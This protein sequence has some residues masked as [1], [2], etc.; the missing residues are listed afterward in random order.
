MNMFGNG[1]P[2]VFGLPKHSP[3]TTPKNIDAMAEIT[4]KVKVPIATGE[5]I[6]TKFGFFEVL[7]KTKVAVIQPDLSI[8]G[9]IME[10]KKIAAI[11]EA[12]YIGIAPHNPYGPILTAASL[13]LD[14]CTPNFVIQEY[15]S[16]GEGILKNPFEIK[17]GY[18]EIPDGP[19][20]GIDIDEQAL[21]KR[22][23][24]PKDVPRLYHEDGAVGDW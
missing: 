19:G 3:N 15:C 14:A 11:A 23:Y 4:E 1:Y 20:L 17:D 7:K 5:R 2:G 18:I 24:V 6:F 12:R 10:G 21:A 9:G 13:H 8:S 22:P 16:L